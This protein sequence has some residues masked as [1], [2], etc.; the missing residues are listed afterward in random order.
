MSLCGTF[1]KSGSLRLEAT[2]ISGA[3]GHTVARQASEAVRSVSRFVALLSRV[4]AAG[5]GREATW[6]R[7][8]SSGRR[9][10]SVPF[11]LQATSTVRSTKRQS[12]P[13]ARIPGPRAAGV[14]ENN[15]EASA[16]TAA[17]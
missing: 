4:S 8:G 15:G 13:P 11:P 6:G 16:S 3:L 7:A 2:E 1:K 14:H 9:G 10:T 12:A 5:P 17:S